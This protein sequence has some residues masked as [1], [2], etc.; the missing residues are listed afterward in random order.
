VKLAGKVALITG[1]AQGQGRA[2]AVR[3]AQ[4]GAALILVDRCEQDPL[5]DYPMGSAEG[6][7]ETERLA[8]AAGAKVVARAADIR[9]SE[10]IAATVA[11][12]VAE[13][14]G[15]DIVVA[16]AAVCS[17][18]PWDRVSPQLWAATLE[19][20]LTGTW[21]TCTAAI[22]HLIQAGGGSIV[23]VSSAAGLSG[24]PYLAPYVASKHG[25]VGIM[26]TLANELG[27]LGI[28]VN[29]LNQGAVDT[30]LGLGA[31]AAMLPLLQARPDL[32]SSFGSALPDP[33]MVPEDVTPAVLYLASDDS[34]FVTGTTLVV[35]AGSL[36]R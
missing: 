26:R 29:T 1:S 21:F 15:L 24:P 10:A 18:Q 5:F 19:T 7:A 32:A 20:N 31:H 3:F 28:R 35:D 16:N 25:I 30:P 27:H 14:G 6:L 9:D 23:L 2:H 33:R 34:R 17:V 13:F 22:P 12:G 8:L 36:N 4:E 11:A